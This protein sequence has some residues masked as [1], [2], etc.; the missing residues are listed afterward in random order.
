MKPKKA[1]K[2]AMGR[3]TK[4]SPIMDT[5]EKYPNIVPI[6]LGYG[7]HCVGCHFSQFDTIEIGAKVHG[8]SQED[9][10]M[11]I[12]DVNAVISQELKV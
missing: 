5:I 7:L 12:K 9:L 2:E 11:M 10:K 6:L 8:M 1:D 3:I 4:E